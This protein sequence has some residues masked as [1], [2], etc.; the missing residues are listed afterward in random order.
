MIDLIK[1]KDVQEVNV[2]SKAKIEKMSDLFNFE[3][4]DE[5][6]LQSDGNARIKERNI[7]DVIDKVKRWRNY[8]IGTSDQKG[9]LI[10][11]SLKEAA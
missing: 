3:S 9:N 2:K 8:Y 5:N 6:W 4:L 11:C 1:R 7:R 10:R